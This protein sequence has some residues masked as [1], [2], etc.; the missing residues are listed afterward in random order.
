MKLS[1][2]Q[3][4]RDATLSSC[5]SSLPSLSRRCDPEDRVGWPLLA[6][7]M[8]KVPEFAAFSRYRDLN[9]KNLLYYQAQLANL[10]DKI[11]QEEDEVRTELGL[12]RYDKFVDNANSQYHVL[13]TELRGLI[14]EY[15][16]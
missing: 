1:E 11:L 2:S 12:E 6:E 7:V 15:S 3:E 4:A 14:K 5:S 10:R 13:M 16:K 9:V 8:S